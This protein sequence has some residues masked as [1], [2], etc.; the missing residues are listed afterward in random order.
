M[1][2]DKAF[3]YSMEALNVLTFESS[4]DKGSLFD[5]D[6]H[7]LCHTMPRTT[8]GTHDTTKNWR[9]VWLFRNSVFKRWTAE[10]DETT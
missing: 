1:I 2:A 3:N 4:G 5:E 6:Y 9:N 8:Y 7:P 10:T